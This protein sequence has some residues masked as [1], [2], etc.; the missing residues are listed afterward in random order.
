[1][2]PVQ[3][4]RQVRDRADPAGRWRRLRDLLRQP[5]MRSSASI[6]PRVTLRGDS[7]LGESIIWHAATARLLWLDLLE[8]RLYSLDPS[9]RKTTSLK[10][11]PA[12]PLGAIVATTDPSRLLVSH[13]GG[14]SVLDL[15]D[16]SASPYADPEAGRDEIAYN[17]C[18]VD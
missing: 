2:L 4:R 10:P 5:D 14:V 8:P 16:G 9:S 6:E 11:G 12:A 3:R 18:K 13:R 17:D 7:R 1:M 15:A